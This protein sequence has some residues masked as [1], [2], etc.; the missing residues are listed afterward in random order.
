MQLNVSKVSF[1]FEP[2]GCVPHLPWYLPM[3]LKK[4]IINN[5]T[6]NKSK[7]KMLLLDVQQQLYSNKIEKQTFYESQKSK[8]KK[9]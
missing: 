4:N 9:K 3:Y 1:L 2:E 7:T 5:S 8:K 6:H